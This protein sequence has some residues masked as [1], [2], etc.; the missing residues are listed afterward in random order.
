MFEFSL[1]RKLALAI[2]KEPEPEPDDLMDTPP[3]PPTSCP[4]PVGSP[5]RVETYR[6]RVELGQHLYHPSDSRVILVR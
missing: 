5:E 4:H 3:L 6:R 2:V 1:R